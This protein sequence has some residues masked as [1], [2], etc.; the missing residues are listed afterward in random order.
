MSL[1]IAPLKHPWLELR[2]CHQEAELR[3]AVE[4]HAYIDTR[5]SSAR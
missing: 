2:P 3:G 1:A 5:D 4:R